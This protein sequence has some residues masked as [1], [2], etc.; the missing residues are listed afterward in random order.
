MAKIL[1]NASCLKTE[2]IIGGKPASANQFPYQVSLRRGNSSFCGGSLISPDVVLT[3]AHCFRRNSTLP[4]TVLAGIV[5]LNTGKGESNTVSHVTLH[6]GFKK[7]PNSLYIND[8]AVLKL[9]KKFNVQNNPKVSTIDLPVNNDKTYAGETA[10]I[11]GY[12]WNKI[13]P[14]V[15]KTGSKKWDGRSEKLLKYALVEVLENHQCK[16][17]FP[18]YLC[19]RVIPQS[20]EDKNLGVCFGDS[21]GP[22]AHNNTLIGVVSQGPM[23]CNDWKRPT[24]YTRVS[25]FLEFIAVAMKTRA[26]D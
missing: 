17:K 25:L 1:A 4:V 15:N 10:L 6:P 5:D 18:S 22:L 24:M 13:W 14:R 8:I 19:G 3:A 2:N 11:S 9:S 21:G 23:S 26:N 7:Q 16:H 20:P 12:G